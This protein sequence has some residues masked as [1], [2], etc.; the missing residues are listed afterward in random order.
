MYI[1]E[2]YVVKFIQIVLGYRPCKV[3]EEYSIYLHVIV[4]I[5][6]EIQSCIFKP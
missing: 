5:A 3:V 2:L 4:S 1:R 6:C